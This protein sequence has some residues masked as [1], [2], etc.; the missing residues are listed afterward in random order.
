MGK[1]I[2]LLLV[3]LKSSL[4]DNVEERNINNSCEIMSHA[5]IFIRPPTNKMIIKS[6]FYGQIN[7]TLKSGV[8][9]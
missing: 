4:Q 6:P 1:H 8:S 2:L 9:P 7:E 3:G 5:D